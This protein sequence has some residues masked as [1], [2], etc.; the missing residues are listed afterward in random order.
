MSN[1]SSTGRY[2]YITP[3]FRVLNPANQIISPLY[4]YHGE[5]SGYD[6]KNQK[7]N[8]EDIQKKLAPINAQL[9]T[10]YVG[11]FMG[12]KRQKTH[13]IAHNDAKTVW[14][15]KYD[16]KRE[17]GSKNLIY[18]LGG[19]TARGG[20]ARSPLT[21]PP[22]ADGGGWGD[23]G[24]WEGYEESLKNTDGGLITVVKHK[25]FIKS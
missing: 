21:P 22:N 20:T 17:G 4:R 14:W 8:L 25:C 24:G 19:G 11:K 5:I 15:R 18:L 12:D 7:K 23:W 6:F 16:E 13:F 9:T 1:L 2:I 3:T 10:I